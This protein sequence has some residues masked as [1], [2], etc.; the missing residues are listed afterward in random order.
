MRDFDSSDH[1]FDSAT[2]LPGQFFA[3]RRKF[4]EP[5]ERLM[6]AVLEDAIRCYQNNIREPRPHARRVFA[7]TK[8]WLF[9]LP[10]NDPFSFEGICEILEIDAPQLRRALRRWRDRELA[11]RQPRIADEHQAAVRPL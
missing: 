5:I 6:F 10:G 8:E 7:E 4:D 11:G 9:A 3:G 1:P 2:I